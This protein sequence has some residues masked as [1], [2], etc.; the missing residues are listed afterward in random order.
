M[1]RAQFHCP[2]CTSVFEA[3][4][5]LAGQSV[6]CPTCT[7]VVTL[8]AA[9]APVDYDLPPPPPPPI[10]PDV[11]PPV[12]G[13]ASAPPPPPEPPHAPPPLPPSWNAVAPS[14]E[15]AAPPPAPAPTSREA[16]PPMAPLAALPA[17]IPPP[18]ERSAVDELPAA[19]SIS[20]AASGESA[21][22]IDINASPGGASRP[23]PLADR[24]AQQDVPLQAAAGAARTRPAAKTIRRVPEAEKAR[25]RKRR[26]IT[27]MVVGALVLLATM[28]VIARLKQ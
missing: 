9:D 23:V 16:L 13:A 17:M 11:P 21:S 7:G 14:A 26:S 5:A 1:N 19:P 10:W 25:R 6:V 15:Y 18:T 12:P 27:M 20:P 8:P 22:A 2:L 24:A 28:F 4:A 3:D